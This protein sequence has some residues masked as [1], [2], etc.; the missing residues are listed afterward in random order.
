MPQTNANITATV[1]TIVANSTN[2]A[3]YIVDT[4]YSTFGQSVIS[5]GTF[6]PIINVHI[7]PQFYSGTGILPDG[8][9]KGIFYQ[10]G[11]NTSMVVAGQSGVEDRQILIKTGLNQWWKI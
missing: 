11:L 8:F 3:L 10:S 1:S 6:V 4:V 5:G 9:A 7:F 2:G